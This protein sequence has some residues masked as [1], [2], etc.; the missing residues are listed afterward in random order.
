MSIWGQDES[1]V[2]DWVYTLPPR[3]GRLRFMRRPTLLTELPIEQVGMTQGQMPTAWKE[4]GTMPSERKSGETV[5]KQK[6][7]PEPR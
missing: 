3:Q 6:G 2:T 1:K 7:K 4:D 5:Q